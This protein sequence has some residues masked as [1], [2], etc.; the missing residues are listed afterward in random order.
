MAAYRSTTGHRHV[1]PRPW[2][3][4]DNLGSWFDI[5][6]LFS[7]LFLNFTRLDFEPDLFKASDLKQ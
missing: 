2:L 4:L 1:S 5:C 7:Q 3:R 6:D